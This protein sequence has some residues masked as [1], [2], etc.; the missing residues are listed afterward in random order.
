M[1]RPPYRVIQRHHVSYAPE[2]VRHVFQSEHNILTRLTRLLKAKLVSYT[3]LFEAGILLCKIADKAKS[4]NEE[5]MMLEFAEN[6]RKRLERKKR[7]CKP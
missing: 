3:F 1:R 5:K 7:R 2:I 6:Q 4:L